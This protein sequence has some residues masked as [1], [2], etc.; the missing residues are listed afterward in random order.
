MKP[1][2]QCIRTNCFLGQILH[3]L[4]VKQERW[5]RWRAKRKFGVWVRA[6]GALLRE[7]GGYHSRKKF[8]LCPFA[9]HSV[10]RARQTLSPAAADRPA[11]RADAAVHKSSSAAQQYSATH[12][13]PAR[14]A[15][16]VRLSRDA[17]KVT[18]YVTIYFLF[19]LT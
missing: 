4:V 2:F 19:H 9:R 1:V 15:S 10:V 13:Q 6:A 17:R 16:P 11:H 7:S 5:E 8:W 18:Q 3:I 14:Q 12:C